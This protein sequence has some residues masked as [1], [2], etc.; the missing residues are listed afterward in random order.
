MYIGLLNFLTYTLRLEFGTI[1]FIDLVYIYIYIC[2]YFLKIPK[3]IFL[4]I[5]Q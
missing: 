4:S 1:Y 3:L 5:Q 2:V